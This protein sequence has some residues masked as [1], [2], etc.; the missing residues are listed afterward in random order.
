MMNLPLLYWASDETGDERYRA[1]A[2]R[3]ADK[4]MQMQVREDGSVH[5]II[6]YDERTGA[7]VCTEGG[8]GYC[9][10]SSWS[11]GQAWGIYGFILS[12]LHTGKQE[13]LDTSKKIA[14][15]FI[16][17]V[18]Q[19]WLPRCDFRAPA[20]PVLYD[21]TAG[22][23]AASGLLELA[24]AVPEGE[25]KLYFDAAVNLLK[26]VVENF[27]D[28]SEDTDGILDFGMERYHGPGH[29]KIVYGDYFLTEAICKLLDKG[30]LFW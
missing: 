9:D 11:R 4:T 24:K 14:H 3:H 1:I 26:A 10:G 17:C 25:Q 19:D 18:C 13:Y 28:W 6:R 2:I 20:Q 15:Y 23:I 21:S 29:M 30:K 16:S 27:A 5:H 8:Q 12:Y 7:L 22:V